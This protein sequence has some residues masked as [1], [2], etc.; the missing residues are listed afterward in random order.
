MKFEIGVGAVRYNEIT[1]MEIPF[2]RGRFMPDKFDARPPQMDV[3]VPDE[4]RILWNERVDPVVKIPNKTLRQVAQL[5]PKPTAETRILVDKMK[6]AM[7]AARG[8]GL[9][10]P[11]MGVS[12][13]VI[14]Y[15]LPEENEPLRV[16]INPKIIT[17]K[18]EQIGP[19]GCLSIPYLQGDVKRAKEVTVKGMDMLGRPFKRRAT[20]F[21]ARIIQHEVDHLDG[22]LFIDRAIQETLEWQEV[23]V[24]EEDSSVKRSP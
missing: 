3:D 5:V 16:V 6:A 22:I 24:L 8:V 21:E 10:A 18:G 17:M 20:D 4:I 11:Q 7:A 9:A 14:I 15:K 12:E 2:I 1:I 23:E 13:R 19:E